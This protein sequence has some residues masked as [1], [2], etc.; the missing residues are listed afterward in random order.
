[1]CMTRLA[2]GLISLLAVSGVQGGVYNQSYDFTATE[3]ASWSDGG[4]LGGTS[5]S[6]NNASGWYSSAYWTVD[7]VADKGEAVLSLAWAKAM[8]TTPTAMAVGDTM[9]I[10]SS[11]AISELPTG[12]DRYLELGL[13]S[14]YNNTVQ[15]GIELSA[16][17]DTGKLSLRP[18]DNSAGVYT[19]S[20]AAEVDTFVTYWLSIKKTAVQSTW[21]VTASIVGDTNGGVTYTI[22]SKDDP[23]GK[24][25]L[26]DVDVYNLEGVLPG[27]VGQ[28]EADVI[29]GEVG[30]VRVDYFKVGSPRNF[31]KVQLLML[32]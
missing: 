19:S 7:Q 11:V 2:S 31:A 23:T 6:T 9:V 32:H 12:T 13:I 5:F 28:G 30:P 4:A 3:Y 24:G 21:E 20:V 8:L 25:D 16:V 29:S 18:S 14:Y 27:M 10:K 1:M 17:S 26:D 22:V 15:V